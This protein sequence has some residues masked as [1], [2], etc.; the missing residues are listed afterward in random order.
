MKL[1]VQ[2]SSAGFG[3]GLM[4][5]GGTLLKQVRGEGRAALS[6]D[7]GALFRSLLADAGVARSLAAL[8]AILVDIGPGGLSSTRAGVSFAN[9]LAFGATIPLFGVSALDLLMAHARETWSGPLLCMR[10][11]QGGLVYWVLFDGDL[12]SASGCDR[13][14]VALA[15][16]SPSQTALIGPL[17]RLRLDPQAVESVRLMDVDPPDMRYFARVPLRAP[18]MFESVAILEPVTSGAELAGASVETPER[19]GTA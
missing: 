11:A 6:R 16:V 2:T 4:D 3:L 19:S 9:A 18:T 1:I 7:L 10:P 13:P 5:D 15:L 14:E 8:E 17:A 12:P